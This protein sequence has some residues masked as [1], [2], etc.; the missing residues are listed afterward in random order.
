MRK[1]VWG[2]A[3]AVVLAGGSC[4]WGAESEGSTML[5]ERSFLAQDAGPKDAQQGSVETPELPLAT[6]WG[7]D[8]LISN[9]GFGMGGFYRRK[10]S[11][12]L[13]GFISF[14]ISGSKDSREVERFDPYT[15]T[16]FTP[17]KLNR[18]IVA[19][20]FAGVQYRLFRE[21]IVDTFRPYVSGGVGPA[22]VYAAPFVNFVETPEGVVRP[23]E[24]EF[25]NSLSQG[26]AYFTPGGYLGFGAFFGSEGSSV[27]GVNIR[28]YF[29]YLL[30]EGIP[31]LY[32]TRTGE[33][34]AY[35]SDFGGFFITLNIGMGG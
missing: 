16:S 12:D 1:L 18:F 35:K 7:L 14:S 27:F 5:P 30:D 10:F 15:G 21:D 26:K 33:V 34:T 22:M 3:A 6:L 2:L 32:D 20:L 29:I 31:S 4:A 25:F 24:I 19:P 13:S 17:G 28:Y 11:P 9:D 8:L 23:E